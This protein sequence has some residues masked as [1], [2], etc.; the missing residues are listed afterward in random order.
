MDL[1]QFLAQPPAPVR[2]DGFSHR[3]ALRLYRERMRRRNALWSAGAA[4]L[5]AGLALLPLGPALRD[6]P[7]QL[8]ALAFSPLVPYLGGAVM[9]LLLVLPPRLLRF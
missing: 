9:L 2:E 6:I 3:I 4:T 8:T 7:L 5:L 1:D